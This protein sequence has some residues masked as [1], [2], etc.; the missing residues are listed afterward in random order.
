M[1]SRP[2]TSRSILDLPRPALAEQFATWGFSPVHVARLWNYLYWEC[3]ESWARMPELPAKVM[4]RLEETY[5]LPVPPVAREAHSTDG[6]TR[7]FLLEQAD[8]RRI[9]TVSLRF[10]GRETA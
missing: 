2:L 7:K 5:S 3:V 9:E 6:F 1:V 4:R 10:T 8:G